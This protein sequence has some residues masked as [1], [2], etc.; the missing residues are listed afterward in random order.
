MHKITPCLWFDDKAEEQQS[1]MPPFL[2]TQRLATLPVMEKKGTRF[3]E[4]R[5][6]R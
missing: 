6:E 1:F 2:K 5:Q 3:T 4:G